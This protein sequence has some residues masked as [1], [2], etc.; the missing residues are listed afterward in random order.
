[1]WIGLS[2]TLS[3]ETNLIQTLPGGESCQPFPSLSNCHNILLQ[4][5]PFRYIWA[6]D[7]S[8]QGGSNRHLFHMLVPTDP[9]RA[10]RSD[11]EEVLD[12]CLHLGFRHMHTAQLAKAGK[13]NRVRGRMAR[14]NCKV[15]KAQWELRAKGK[16]VVYPVWQLWHSI[17]PNSV[18]TKGLS[19]PVVGSLPTNGDEKG[20][21]GSHQLPLYGWTKSSEKWICIIGGRGRVL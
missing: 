4:S 13:D 16:G 17:Q 7:L 15:I 21:T 14:R 5:V 10:K 20:R 8:A 3:L 2:A 6:G 18:F 9:F 1:M 19:N 11:V 12:F